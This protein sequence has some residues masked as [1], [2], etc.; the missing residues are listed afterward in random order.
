MPLPPAIRWSPGFGQALALA[1]IG[2]VACGGQPSNRFVTVTVTFR[3][4]EAG[5][6]TATPAGVHVDWPSAVTVE[7][8]NYDGQ[9]HGLQFTQ[10]HLDTVVGA[11][12][13]A[14]PSV[15][16]Y[17]LDI[18][19]PGTFAWRCSLNCGDRPPEGYVHVA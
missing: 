12:A 8:V 2:L 11:G 1:I 10:L 9:A 5:A 19:G 4:A 14:S 7:L 15:A 16:Y 13:E 17:A 3:L 6:L 18:R